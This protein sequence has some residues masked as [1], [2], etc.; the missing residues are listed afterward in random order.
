[1]EKNGIKIGFLGYWDM[2]TPY[3]D[4]SSQRVNFR[5]GSAIYEDNVAEDDIKRLK[6]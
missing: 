4:S 3:K 6:V 5:A 1:M 2:V